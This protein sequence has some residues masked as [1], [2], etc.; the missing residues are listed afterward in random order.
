[1]KPT[2]NAPSDRI[3]VIARTPTYANDS[4][5]LA[6]LAGLGWLG[7]AWAWAGPGLAWLSLGLL[8]WLDLDWTEL[9]V[10]GQ[11][12][13]ELAGAWL[14]KMECPIQKA[15]RCYPERKDWLARAGLAMA[16]VAWAS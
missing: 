3:C 6:G 2:R 5:G 8:G 11:V 9:A 13:P 16:W 4:D 1:M 14:G 10:L 12:G 15:I 7:W